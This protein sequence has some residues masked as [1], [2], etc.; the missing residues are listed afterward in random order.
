MIAAVAFSENPLALNRSHIVFSLVV[1]HLL[2]LYCVPLMQMQST[3]S[4]HCMEQ[5]I[6]D[7][8]QKSFSFSQFE[9]IEVY[10]KVTSKK[11]AGFYR[12]PAATSGPYVL[13]LFPTVTTTAMNFT[14]VQQFKVLCQTLKSP[15]VY[16]LH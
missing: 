3:R 16:Q 1:D 4:P 10:F 13:Y 7:A 14:S 12:C 6:K 8:M 15:S 5:S 9:V 2:R 11:Y